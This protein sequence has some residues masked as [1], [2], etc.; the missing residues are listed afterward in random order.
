MKLFFILFS[1]CFSP[2]ASFTAGVILTAAG[3]Y[4][5]KSAKKKTELPLATIPLIFGIH[6]LMEGGVW[7]TFP[8]PVAH[9]I[10]TYLF[11]GIAYVFWPAYIPFAVLSLEKIQKNKKILRY[12]QIAGIVAAL[13]ML[14]AIL[15]TPVDSFVRQNSICYNVKNITS[16]I[17]ILYI[18]ALTLPQFFSSDKFIRLFGIGAIVSLAISYYFYTATFASVWCFF[19]AILSG[20]IYFHFSPH[21]KILKKIRK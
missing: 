19:A 12:F 21:S 16:L 5:I 11:V 17:G 15:K 4:T 3:I 2:E 7:V 1:M 14:F 10:F 6:Q 9:T 18:A 8:Y 13:G 20:S